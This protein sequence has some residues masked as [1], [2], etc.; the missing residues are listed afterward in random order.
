MKK[1]GIILV[2]LLVL[3]SVVF[4]ANQTIQALLADD[5]TIKLNGEV[6]SMRDSNGGVVHPIVYNG[7]TY[8]P[9]RSISETLGLDVSWDGTT[10]T[11]GLTEKANHVE[12]T[13]I[14]STNKDSYGLGEWWVVE[15]LW[16]LKIDSVEIVTDRNQFSE[17]NPAEVVKI[18]YTYENLGYTDGDLYI[19]IDNVVDSQRKAADTYPL[20]DVRHKSIPV[21]TISEKGAEFF[22]LVSPNNETISI[23]FEKYGNGLD[24]HRTKFVVPVSR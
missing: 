1:S 10:K 17:K 11:V 6:L 2:A 22:G 14:Q 5:I 4:A 18:T 13:Q 12:N 15:G 21:G 23:Y 24:K 19:S 7:I 20:S 3:S 16:K 8:L 9:L